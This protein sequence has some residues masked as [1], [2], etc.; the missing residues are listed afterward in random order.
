[1]RQLPSLQAFGN[2]EFKEKIETILKSVLD[3][4]QNWGRNTEISHILFL[5]SVWLLWPYGVYVACQSPLTMEFPRQES[6]SGL[7]FSTP[8]DLPNPGIDPV[9]PAVQVDS[10]PLSQRE[11]L[12][13]HIPPPKYACVCLRA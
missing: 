12:I 4:Q 11:G 8:E 3:T 6:W 2:K 10:L 5:F 9:S 7:P 13:S 1:M